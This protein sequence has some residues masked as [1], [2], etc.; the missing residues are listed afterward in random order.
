[1]WQYTLRKPTQWSLLFTVQVR[2]ASLIFH[3]LFKN[4]ILQYF[5]VVYPELISKGDAFLHYGMS[6]P[7]CIWL[8]ANVLQTYSVYYDWTTVSVYIAVAQTLCFITISAATVRWLYLVTLRQSASRFHFNLLTLEEFTFFAYWFPA[9]LYTPTAV[10]W[11]I[12]T[13]DLM[14]KNH[15]PENLMFQMCCHC[16]MGS[17]IIGTTLFC[18]YVY[19]FLP[20]VFRFYTEKYVWQLLPLLYMLILLNPDTHGHILLCAK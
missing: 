16:F 4:A 3:L 12:A 9:L 10:F 19:V 11:K 2:N 6:W 8:I 17:L 18:S 15:T 7:F 14:W 5:N 13:A 20:L 1:M